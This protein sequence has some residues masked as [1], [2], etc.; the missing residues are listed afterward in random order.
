MD[1]RSHHLQKRFLAKAQ[2]NTEKFADIPIIAYLCTA[3][4]NTTAIKMQYQ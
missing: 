2:K 3:M 4:C 1:R